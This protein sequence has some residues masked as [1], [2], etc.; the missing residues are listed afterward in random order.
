MYRDIEKAEILAK[1]FVKIHSLK[2]IPASRQ[3]MSNTIAQHPEIKTKNRLQ[4][5]MLQ[6]YIYIVE[7]KES[8]VEGT[9]SI[10][11]VNGVW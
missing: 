5:V 2:N 3:N 8:T 4:Q 7:S 6:S 11:K 10:T 9:A 1:I